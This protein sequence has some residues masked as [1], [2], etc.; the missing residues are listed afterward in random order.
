MSVS[1]YWTRRF[2]V[3]GSILVVVLVPVNASAAPAAQVSVSS[4]CSGGYVALTF[5]DGPNASNTWAL[6]DA[7]RSAGLRA[8]MFSVGR[9]IHRYA[10]VVRAESDAGMWLGNHSWSHKHMTRLSRSEME[11]EL[12][13][14]QE[15]IHEVTGI[16]PRF[17]RAPYVESSDELRSVAAELGLMEV[18][19]GVDSG[20]WRGASAHDIAAAAYR[21]TAG[22]VMVMHDRRSA[23]VEAIPRIA[24]ILD[25]RGLCT[26][27]LA[28]DSGRAVG[29]E[30][31]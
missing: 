11:W 8:T 14:T 3:I 31:E 22:D 30:E 28:D 27:R 7:L 4:D 17:F 9:N 13:E 16:W 20:D 6:L 24:R 23:T 26:G 25:E 18:P 1:S 12:R 21:L 5:D 19:M 15:A 10:E 29:P 2:L